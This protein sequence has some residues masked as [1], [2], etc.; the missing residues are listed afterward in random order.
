MTAKREPREITMAEIE[1]RFNLASYWFGDR[2]CPAVSSYR[3]GYRIRVVKSETRRGPNVSTIYDYFELDA[4]GTVTVA[5]WGYA[6]DYKPGRIVDIAAALDRYAMPQP[7]AR[8]I[9]L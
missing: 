2:W 1:Q 7:D 8:R 5:P 4:D 6:R 3:D 9:G